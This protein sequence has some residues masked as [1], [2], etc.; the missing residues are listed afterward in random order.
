MEKETHHFN[1]SRDARSLWQGI[2]A[3]TDYK[4]PPQTCASDTSLLNNLN[5]F[6]A[7][8][9]AN[10]HMPRQK[11]PTPPHDQAL[12]LSAASVKRTLHDQQPQ[13]PET[14]HGRVLK[15][16]AEELKDVFTDIFNTP[17]RQA[18][19]PIHHHHPRAKEACSILL[20]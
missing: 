9:E 1:D 2:Q 20:Q 15:E 14:I 11:T 4:S 6:F 13:G 12:C 3:I 16:C 5:S 7:Q 8:F 19:V 17:L 10:N 18:V